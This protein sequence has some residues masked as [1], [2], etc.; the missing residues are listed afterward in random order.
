MKEIRQNRM[1]WNRIKDWHKGKKK[2]IYHLKLSKM[3]STECAKKQ[4]NPELL[5]LLIQKCF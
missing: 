1:E 3:F 5:H 4:S 2:M